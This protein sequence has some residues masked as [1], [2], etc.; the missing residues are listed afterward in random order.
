MLLALTAIKSA[1]ARTQP[2]VH[3]LEAAIL[4]QQHQVFLQ[5]LL[6]AHGLPTLGDATMLMTGA[7]LCGSN[8][9]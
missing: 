1:V 8:T 3:C 6:R 4:L 7:D 5:V 2:P 9:P